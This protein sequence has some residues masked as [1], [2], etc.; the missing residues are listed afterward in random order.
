MYDQNGRDI[1]SAR[2]RQ[3]RDGN[4]GRMRLRQAR[5]IAG[6]CK[7]LSNSFKYMIFI[8]IFSRAFYFGAIGE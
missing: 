6:F 4:R 8:D 1:L 3:V 2:F 7:C 5:V